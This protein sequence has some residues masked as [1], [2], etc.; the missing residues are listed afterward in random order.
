MKVATEELQL[1]IVELEEENAELWVI[2]IKFYQEV[3]ALMRSK[4]LGG[5]NAT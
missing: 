4:S 2:L 3:G 5:S 1:R